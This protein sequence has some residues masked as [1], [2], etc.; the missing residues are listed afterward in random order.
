MATKKRNLQVKETG[1]VESK[2][3]SGKKTKP[4]KKQKKAKT[5][6]S[7]EKGK[8]KS[9]D[10][11]RV[12]DK[13]KDKDKEETV[14]LTDKEQPIQP[15]VFT[16][17]EAKKN[18]QNVRD[19]LNQ[20]FLQAASKK[21]GRQLDEFL[22]LLAKTPVERLS[23]PTGESII[24]CLRTD[25]I[26]D[27]FQKILD[28]NI[29][30]LPV[31]KAGGMYYGFVDLL[32][33]VTWLVDQVGSLELLKHSS[34]T[35]P[36]TQENIRVTDRILDRL[37]NDFKTTTVGHVMTYPVSKSNPFHPVPRG[38]S[39]L[40]VMEILA[41]GVHRLPVLGQG[42]RLMQIVTQSDIVHWVSDHLQLLGK[43]RA[44]S[45][46]DMDS[47]IQ[48]VLS[49]SQ[50][51]RTIDAFRMMRIM[52]VSGLAVVN[53]KGRMIANLSAKD[54]KKIAK[55]GK[56]MSRLFE[57]VGSFR[58]HRKTLKFVKLSNTLEDVFNLFKRHQIHR[59][60]IV[61]DGMYPIGVISLTDIIRELLPNPVSGL[62][63]T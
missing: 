20:T 60:Y 26:A 27:A 5:G 28:N 63:E 29:L 36:P 53:K 16:E 3:T 11:D 22:L 34:P 17:E 15:P 50:H 48:Y 52:R 51:E 33:I 58:D 59:V 39:L 1:E 10:K 37:K 18:E 42:D 46:R 23:S 2:D 41:T 40:S 6:D 32:D 19:L 12:K 21:E 13:D 54:L 57:E 14:L 35:L 61:D 56:Y 47:C 4:S 38:T 43:M 24:T 31:I 62:S 45:V 55:D 25:T 30:S 49:V 44:L 7:K 8:R 9:K